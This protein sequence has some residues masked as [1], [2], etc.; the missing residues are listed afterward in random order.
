MSRHQDSADRG[1][2]SGCM[3][4]L[5]VLLLFISAGE[6]F[7]SGCQTDR[8]QMV[9]LEVLPPWVFG[10]IV[11]GCP[12]VVLARLVWGPSPWGIQQHKEEEQTREQNDQEK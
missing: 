6:A 7:G 10:L 5:V 2:G 8:S 1:A 9:A 4:H 3:A 12:L 11:V